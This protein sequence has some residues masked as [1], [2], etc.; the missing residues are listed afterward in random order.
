MDPKSVLPACR[1]NLMLAREIGFHFGNQHKS[2]LVTKVPR[3]RPS[4]A[5]QR[6]AHGMFHSACL[7][8]IPIPAD[9]GSSH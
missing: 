7:S 6:L 3:F 1:A 4:E 9:S 2:V 8:A 5:T